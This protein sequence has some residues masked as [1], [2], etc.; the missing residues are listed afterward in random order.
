MWKGG[1]LYGGLLRGGRLHPVILVMQLY[2][3]CIAV[4]LFLNGNGLLG[5]TL[6]SN[7]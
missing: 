2:I 4:H 7:Y 1:G 5:R 3:Y 6:M